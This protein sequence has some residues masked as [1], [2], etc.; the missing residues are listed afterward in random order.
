[1]QQ[2]PQEPVATILYRIE[3]MERDVTQLKTQLSLYV[4]AREN[5]L[6][7][8]AINDTVGRIET[9]LIKVKDKLETMNAR[10]A[11][12]SQELQT[13]DAQQREDQNKLQ[14]RVLWFIVST[15]IG[16]LCAVL[17]A[18]LTHFF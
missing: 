2:Q 8:Q 3:T 5:D 11:A 4:P 15:V 14:I 10:M 13:K 7:T 1:M 17:I 9:E 6:R 18:Y 12:Q 16:I